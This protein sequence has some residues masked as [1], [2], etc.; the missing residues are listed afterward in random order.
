[1]TTNRHGSV[2]GT[3]HACFIQAKVMKY[4]HFLNVEYLLNYDLKEESLSNSYNS[5]HSHT[6][7]FIE[8][9]QKVSLCHSLHTKKVGNQKKN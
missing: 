9:H 4:F 2:P 6:V 1:M 5:S 3:G 8:C 7:L